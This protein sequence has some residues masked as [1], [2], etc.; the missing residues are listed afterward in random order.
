MQRMEQGFLSRQSSANATVV[1]QRD[2]LR[3]A[4][5]TLQSKNGKLLLNI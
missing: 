5:A 2:R 1:L 4:N 3:T